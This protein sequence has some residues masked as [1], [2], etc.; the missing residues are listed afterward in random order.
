MDEKRIRINQSDSSGN[1]SAKL[2]RNGVEV[3][4]CNWP[5]PKDPV[6]KISKKTIEGN[7]HNAGN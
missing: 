7:K 2:I 3:P 6:E 5:N 4:R 1:L